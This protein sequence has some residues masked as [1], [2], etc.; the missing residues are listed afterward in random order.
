MIRRPPR[1]TL[2]PYTTLFRS[3]AARED[4]VEVDEEYH[5]YAAGELR[6]EPKAV[7][8]IR[9]VLEGPGRGVLDRRSVRQ[10]VGERNPDLDHVRPGLD[11]SLRHLPRPVERRIAG[12]EVRYERDPV[13]P[14][15]RPESLFT[16]H[17]TLLPPLP[18]RC[19]KRSRRPRRP[20]RRGPRG[21]RRGSSPARAPSPPSRR[22]RWHGP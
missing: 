21:L 13:I 2:F 22:R 18:I 16:H 14:K 15:N 4:A 10:R 9:A 7:G 1:S 19:P 17:R 11:V 8:Q 6:S 20:C 3:D 12:S 5:R